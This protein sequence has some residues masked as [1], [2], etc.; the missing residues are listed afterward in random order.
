M[1][2]GAAHQATAGQIQLDVTVTDRAGRPIKGL[3]RGDFTLLDNGRPIPIA[4]FQAQSI[5]APS[6]SAAAARQVEQILVIIDT[7]NVPFQQVSYSR[8]G[9]DRFLRADDGQ[10]PAPTSIFWYTEK[11]LE[12]G[13]DPTTDGNALAAKVDLTEGRLRQLTR[14]AGFWGAVERFSMSL[15]TLDRVARIES[16]QPGRKLIIWVGPG[17]PMFSNPSMQLSV[18]QE[19]SLFR[20]VVEFSTLLR[21]A[22]VT[23]YSVAAGV[24]SRYGLLY[25]GFLKGVKNASQVTVPDLDLKVLA[26]QSGG[27]ALSPSNDLGGEIE[28]CARDAAAWY[29]IGFTPP[30]ARGPNEYHALKVRV[31]K[32]GLTARTSAGYYNQPA[33]AQAR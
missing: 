6:I 17:W 18:Q 32:R 2:H 30:P 23:L 16:M 10:L 28:Q 12:S 24:P 3:D 22:H 27:L 4:S 15:K 9:I 1:P 21:Q 5:Q 11:G 7:I 25:E 20:D 26:V 14:A 19:Q 33:Q 29:T 31:D 13:E 8:V